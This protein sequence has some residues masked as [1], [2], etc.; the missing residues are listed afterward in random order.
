MCGDDVRV[1]VY[2]NTDAFAVFGIHPTV[3]CHPEEFCEDTLTELRRN[4]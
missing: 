2:A 4:A 1:E 3:V